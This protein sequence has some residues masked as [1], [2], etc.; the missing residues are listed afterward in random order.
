MAD[1]AHPKYRAPA[2]EKGL[3]VLELLAGAREPMSLNVISRHLK[4]SFSDLFRMFQ[5]L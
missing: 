5:V 2:L 1:S 3:A 4:R